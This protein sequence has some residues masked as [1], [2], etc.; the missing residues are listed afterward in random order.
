M[1]TLVETLKK[2]TESLR[3]Q[4]LELTEKWAK[5]QVIR[6][7]ERKNKYAEFG[8]KLIEII[9]KNAYYQEQKYYYNTPIWHFQPE[10]FVPKMLKEAEL[11]YQNSIEKLAFRIEEKGLNQNNITIKT[12]HIGVNINTTLTDGNKI[13]KAFTIIAS[14]PI[15]R[16]HYRYLI[17]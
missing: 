13:V 16:P 7:I 15:Q 11:H 8:S 10:Q 2:E 12:S 17:K 6:N 9:G 14:G 4:Y 5:E 1:K 3:I